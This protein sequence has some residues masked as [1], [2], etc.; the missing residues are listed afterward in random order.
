[1]CWSNCS[2]FIDFIKKTCG[3]YYSMMTASWEVNKKSIRNDI[4]TSTGW[5]QLLHMEAGPGK[6]GKDLF[7]RELAE[8]RWR[9]MEGKEPKGLNMDLSVSQ[10]LKKGRIGSLNEGTL[11]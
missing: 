8:A 6:Q 5:V 3:V 4:S 9:E 1:M 10:R 2:G 7:L 11:K